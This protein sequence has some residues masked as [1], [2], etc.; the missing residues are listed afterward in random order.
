MTLDDL[1][2][3]LLAVPEDKPVVF[4]TDEGDV[5]GGYHLTELKH[6]RVTSLDCAGRTEVWTE[7]RVQLL[8][9]SGGAHMT[10]RRLRAILEKSV[11]HLPEAS[12]A[13]ILIEYAPGNSGLRLFELALPEAPQDARLVMRLNERHA[14]CKPA[15]AFEQ[16]RAPRTSEATGSRCCG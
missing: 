10:A 15:A 3:V 8:D 11:A 1:E 14:T 4:A 5:P 6:A 16:R 9:G 12:K 7:L 13:E 2:H